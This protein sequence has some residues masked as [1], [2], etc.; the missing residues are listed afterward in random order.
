MASSGIKPIVYQI[1][2]LM[3]GRF[4]I[5]VTKLGL[6]VR[7]LQHLKE[8]RRGKFDFPIYRAIRKYGEDV[9]AFVQL[10]ECETYEEAL[11]KEV[12]MIAAMAPAYNATKGGQ[13]H[14]HWTGKTRDVETNKKIS[15]TKTGIPRGY[16][17]PHA[18][19]I[20]R[21][22]MRRAARSRRKPV[23]C[24]NDGRVF[25]SAREASLH[26]NF[27]VSS[28]SKVAAGKRRQISGLTF[29]YIQVM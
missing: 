19:E 22:N 21:E 15:A 29:E 17:P 1:I 5:G 24:I 23:R 16:T 10:C 12:E 8:A 13:G 3:N 11:S 14:A 28:V 4:Y 27:D 7:R 2:N 20:F 25:D 26:Y 6:R 18:L 9:F